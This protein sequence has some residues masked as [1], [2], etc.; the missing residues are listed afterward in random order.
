MFCGGQNGVR[1][2]QAHCRHKVNNYVR[3]VG[4]GRSKH[5]FL[6]LAFDMVW[7]DK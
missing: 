3:T 2:A 4:Y 7:Y 6:S 1:R 5:G